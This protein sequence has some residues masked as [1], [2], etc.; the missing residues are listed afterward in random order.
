MFADA[1]TFNQLIDKWNVSNVTNMRFMFRGATSMQRE[2]V[3]WY[4]GQFVEKEEE[5]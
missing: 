2:N 3:P 1:K 4:N 5:E